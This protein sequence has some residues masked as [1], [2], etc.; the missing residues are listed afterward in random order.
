MSYEKHVYAADLPADTQQVWIRE[1]N[2]HGIEVEFH[3]SFDM[4]GWSGG[5][6][7]CRLLVKPG[8]C[9]QAARYGAQPFQAG[10]EFLAIRSRVEISEILG[11]FHQELLRSGLKLPRDLLGVLSDSQALFCF[12]HGGFRWTAA[13]F[14]VCW[15]AAAALARV[16]GGLLFDEWSDNNDNGFCYAEQA[17]EVA[18]QRSALYEADPEAAAAVWEAEPFR[19]WS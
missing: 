12:T 4:F 18:K 7:P 8:A 9:P 6:L 3:P 15:Y 19:G 17:L 5:Y 2:R 13:D 14:R 1:M 10:F 16:T 11:E